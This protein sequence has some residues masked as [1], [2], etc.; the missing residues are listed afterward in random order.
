[1]GRARGVALNPLSVLVGNGVALAFGSDSPVTPVDPWATVRAAVHHRTPG[2]G[3]SPRAA[4]TAHTRGGWRAAGVED[5][6]S[7]TLTPGAPATYAVWEAG[8]LVGP[9]ADDRVRRW[10]TDPRSGVP[11]LPSVAP[12]VDLPVCVRTVLRGRTIFDA[13]GR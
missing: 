4:F 6:V 11:S 7:G 2:F 10:S 8:E 12:G 3:V 1:L 5:G 9:P 13:G